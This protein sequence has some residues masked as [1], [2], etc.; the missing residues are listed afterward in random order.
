MLSR[1]MLVSYM[2]QEITY[3]PTCNIVKKQIPTGDIVKLIIPLK[4]RI[5][6]HPTGLPAFWYKVLIHMTVGTTF[7]CKNLH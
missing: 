3:I 4:Y 5:G 1:T 2:S 6:C 7:P